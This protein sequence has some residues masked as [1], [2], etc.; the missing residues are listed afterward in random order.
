[1]NVY[2]ENVFH[3]LYIQIK[4]KVSKKF[5]SLEKI[6]FLFFCEFQL[7]LHEMKYMQGLC[8]SKTICGIFH[9][10][11]LLIFIKVYNLVPQN[12]WTL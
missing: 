6:P 5:P 11:F 2:S 12:S 1:M 9:F 4:T 10:P 3:T 7:I 8:L